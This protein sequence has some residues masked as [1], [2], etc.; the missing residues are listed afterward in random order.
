MKIGIISDIHGN[1][2]SLRIVLNE[3]KQCDVIYNLGDNVGDEGDSNKVIELI[4][5]E[6]IKNILGNHDLEILLGKT[7]PASRF[8]A[9][10]LDG[11][12]QQL[13]TGYNITNRTRHFIRNLK[14]QYIIDQDGVTYGFYHSLSDKYKGDI[15]FEYITKRNALDFINKSGCDIA[16][17][18]H[19]HIPS[20]TA[21]GS[22]DNVFLA[23]VN[24]SLSF[25]IDSSKRM[26]INVGSVG[27]VRLK[28]IGYSY[29]VLDTINK[30]IE[31]VL[32][33][34]ENPQ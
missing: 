25:K 2:K 10:L 12:S 28:N 13:R 24:K 6:H 14:S 33:N 4:D 29:A 23:N 17:V 31:M 15:Y 22:D 16:F 8:M 27:A 20:L 11:S 18:G 32:I 34:I 3:L 1:D 21:I 19:K 9:E 5:R 30:T 7:I 26:I